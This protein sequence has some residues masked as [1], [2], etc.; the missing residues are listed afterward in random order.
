MKLL[1]NQNVKHNTIEPAAATADKTPESP[2]ITV[3]TVTTDD[4]IPENE[5]TTSL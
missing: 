5:K 4:K 2:V 3:T 1:Q